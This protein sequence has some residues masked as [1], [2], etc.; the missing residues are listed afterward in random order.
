MV[1]SGEDMI[2]SSAY[3]APRRAGRAVLAGSVM[4]VAAAAGAFAESARVADPVAAARA[5][6]ESICLSVD[7]PEDFAVRQDLTG[8]G[9][10]DVILRYAVTCDGFANRFCGQSG[11]DGG[12]FVAAPDGGF[13]AT[14]L[15]PEVEATE[16]EGWP[17]VAVRR[18]GPRC[19]GSTA[20]RCRSIMV[21]DGEAFV[22]PRAVRGEAPPE[23]V[24]EEPEPD[25]R[26]IAQFPAGA[27]LPG[28][29]PGVLSGRPER[30]AAPPPPR[31]PAPDDDLGEAAQPLSG[32]DPAGE[33]LALA[34]PEASGGDPAA[35]ET[36]QRTAAAG[37]LPQDPE[38]TVVLFDPSSGVPEIPETPERPELPEALAAL[39]TPA[40]R[41]AWGFG[42]TGAGRLVAEILADTGDGL[43][44]LSCRPGEPTLTLVYFDGDRAV[45]GELTLAEFIV[46]RRVAE[47]R[48][49]S[50][51]SGP[52]V[53]RD[54]IA[55][56]GA[57][58]TTLRRFSSV[59][60]RT[61]SRSGAATLFSLRGSSRSL[62]AL[63]AACDL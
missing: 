37:A 7:Y 23:P 19:A 12:V 57:L 47:T 11:C 6:I 2:D 10:A 22:E 49:L 40:T 63:L 16:H 42:R 39:E 25:E 36:A 31:G 34:A 51:A 54:S 33:E 9:R 44:R 4:W 15:P 13:V 43:L 35:P 62:G 38:R 5:E 17:A 46:G 14:E 45:D 3:R 50:Y 52:G 24:V 30:P 48:L 29:V 60:V 26:A 58:I 18:G 32:G 27:P 1:Q 53:W 28:A 59:A 8:D 61:A 55:P 20:A 56:N 21:W 41:D